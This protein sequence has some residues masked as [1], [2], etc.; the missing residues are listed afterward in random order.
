MTFRIFSRLSLSLLVRGSGIVSRTGQMRM[1]LY[2]IC[3]SP[4]AYPRHSL[5]VHV[6]AQY[7]WLYGQCWWTYM[8]TILSACWLSSARAAPTIA[9]SADSTIIK[10]E[11]LRLICLTPFSY[12]SFRLRVFLG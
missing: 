7:G 9:Q 6:R 1:V 11:Y 2:P 8:P 12:L 3:F 10:K 4:P 5:S